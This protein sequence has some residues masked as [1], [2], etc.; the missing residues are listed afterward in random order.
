MIN[1]IAIYLAKLDDPSCWCSL[2]RIKIL[3]FGI[4]CLAVA[5]SETNAEPIG[6]KPPNI[7]VRIKPDTRSVQ[8]QYVIKLTQFLCL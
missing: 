7:L 8:H 4:L 2:R 1:S 5:H 3:V 6:E